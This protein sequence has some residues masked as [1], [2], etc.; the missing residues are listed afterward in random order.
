MSALTE[1]IYNELSSVRDVKKGELVDFIDNLTKNLASLTQ[2]GDLRLTFAK[3][4]RAFTLGHGVRSAVYTSLTS[5]LQKNMDAISKQNGLADY[6]FINNKGDIIASHAKNNDL[7]TNVVS[8]PLKGTLLSKGFLQASKTK[9]T[10]IT[11]MVLYPP[12]GGNPRM[13]IIIPILNG[14]EPT[15]FY[16]PHE[17]I[18]VMVASLSPSLIN[19]IL[20]EG[21]KIGKTGE[22][23][24]V[25]PDKLMRSDSHLDPK[26]RSILS[27]LKNPEKGKVDSPSVLAALSGEKGVKETMS[28]LG[29]KVIS[30]YAP[31]ALSTG[32][33]WAIVVEI[34]KSEAFAPI[35]AIRKITFIA[36]AVL[37]LV[38][39]I[40]ALFAS[41]NITRP[42]KSILEDLKALA[43]GDL[44]R[45]INVASKDEIGQMAQ[46]LQDMLNGVI[47]E[48]QSIKNGI[49]DPFIITT[50]ERD[51]V[52]MNEA[53]AEL[54]GFSVV[55]AVGK[56]KGPQIFNPNNLPRC[57]VCNTLREAEEKNTSIIGKKVIMKNR[58]GKELD[59]AVSCTPLKNL[60]G[61]MIGGMILLRD[62]TEDIEQERALEENQ[63]LLLEVAKE[64][65]SIA[66]QVATAAEILTNQSDEIATGAEEQSMQANQVAAAVE[67]MNA[68]I[69]EVAR[70]A[71]DAANRSK[72]TKNV[73]VQG[74]QVVEDSVKK[75]KR[76]AQT[77]QNVAES[78]E[79]LAE[80][81]QEI[82][83]VIDVISDI[84]AQ[85]NLLALNATIEA[86]SAGEA[87]K[88]FAVVAGEV[89]ELAKQ[90][91]ASTESV[92]EA[93]EQIQEG[94]KQAVA[95][96][97]E[98]LKEVS[99]STA[100]ANE[101]GQSLREIV[102]KAE[103]TAEM[104]TGIA[105]A[106]QQQSAAVGEISKNV[107]GITTVSHQTARGIAETA[108]AVK[109][110]ASLAEQL[111]ETAK[112]FQENR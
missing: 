91:A 28:Y 105:A 79:A 62:I 34:S 108:A 44:T 48:G 98:T 15:L 2:T 53:C 33:P 85:T 64:V 21:V 40:L 92:G 73:A 50:L 43:A 32:T 57:E 22:I 99:E 1:R 12:A 20:W 39:I 11:D 45:H 74:S 54:T 61:E 58:E 78:V 13:F 23:F 69:A 18:G 31:L 41:S 26:N 88:G 111:K 4:N 71:Q 37:Y 94:I 76:L 90:T 95:M 80:K 100:L 109:E 16:P 19:S 8:G 30:A 5:A 42:I 75:I 38:V 103:D 49:P 60:R 87:G 68:T 67:E 59:L 52:F 25:G 9:K 93:I 66:N 47:G 104:V 86:A 29:Q 17:Y 110:L 10:V 89:K 35:Y 56:L 55:E 84:A 72:E 70:S 112:R 96:I 6:L 102:A 82:D 3:F 81:S 63:R 46:A 7:G 107:D 65:Q 36:G 51:I 101:A 14:E 24:L 106:A 97:E 77:S 83:K 27:S